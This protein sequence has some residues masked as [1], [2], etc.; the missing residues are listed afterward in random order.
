MQFLKRLRGPVKHGEVTTSIRIWKRPHV[1]VGNRY[2][3]DEGFIVVDKLYQIA[4]DDI[5]AAMARACGFSSVTDLL[6]TAK[7]G[8]GENVYLV[9]F[10][11]EEPPGPG[12]GGKQ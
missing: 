9:E 3:L 10:H 7:H 6:K 8:Q 5:T 1:K 4:L 11:Y 12:G 2:R